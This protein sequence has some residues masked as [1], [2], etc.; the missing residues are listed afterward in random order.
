MK[1]F[2]AWNGNPETETDLIIDIEH[3]QDETLDLDEIKEP[4]R[5]K[6]SKI[7]KLFTD[8]Y[9]YELIKLVLKGGMRKSKYTSKKVSTLTFKIDMLFNIECS[10]EENSPF[11]VDQYLSKK[12]SEIAELISSIC[13]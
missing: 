2:R 11:E 7:N 10:S 6:P 3:Y 12:E 9:G 8:A 5:S 4:Y 13:E 1:K